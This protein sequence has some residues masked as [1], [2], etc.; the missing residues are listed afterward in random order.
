MV[1]SEFVATVAVLPLDI[2]DVDESNALVVHV[3]LT[4]RHQLLSLFVAL[5]KDR[6]PRSRLDLNDLRA[7][8]CILDDQFVVERVD[9]SAVIRLPDDVAVGPRKS[10]IPIDQVNLNNFASIGHPLERLLFQLDGYFLPPTLLHADEVSVAEIHSLGL[11]L[12]EVLGLLLDGGELLRSF[13][14]EV[15]NQSAHFLEH[16]HDEGVF[17]EFRLLV[18]FHEEAHLLKI[19]RLVEGV[20]IWVSEHLLLLTLRVIISGGVSVETPYVDAVF[21]TG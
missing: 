6:Q 9:D 17:G 4:H 21:L 20:P 10:V 16:G 3:S 8:L 19:A 12:V 14:R 11:L 13:Q 7:S 18:V 15:G 2:E 1:E 5:G